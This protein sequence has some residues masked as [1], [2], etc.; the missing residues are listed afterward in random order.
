[1]PKVKTEIKQENSEDLPLLVTNVQSI[2]EPPMPK[3]EKLPFDENDANKPQ[4]DGSNTIP[5]SEYAPIEYGPH[6]FGCPF[7]PKVVPYYGNM[8]VH[9]RLHTGEKPFEC[10]NCEKSFI[11]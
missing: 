10:N 8:K 2:N 4:S 5:N 7:C 3:E 6:K 9:I 1:M 11:C